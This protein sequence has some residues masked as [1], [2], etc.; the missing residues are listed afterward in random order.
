MS[1]AAESPSRTATVRPVPGIGGMG[2]MQPAVLN[3]LEDAAEEKARLGNTQRAVLNILEDVAVEQERLRDV[4]RGVFNILEDAAGERAQLRDVQRGLY[5]ILE[6]VDAERSERGRAEETVRALNARLEE[7]IDALAAANQELESFSYSV[8]HDLRAPLRAIDGFSQILIEDY[9][10]QLD[11]EGKDALNRVRAAAQRMSNLIDDMLRLSRAT[12][13]QMAI[14]P[15]DLS[16]IAA[17]VIEQLTPPERRPALEFSVQPGVI[18][19]GDAVLLRAVMENLLSNALKFTSR[20]TRGRIAFAAQRRG[21]EVICGVADDGAGFDMQ[22]AKNL[23]IPFQRLH[24]AADFP[25]NGVGLATVKRIISRLGGRVWADGAP[26]KGATFYF[27]LRD[28]G[29]D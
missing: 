6:D 27:T 29:A 5:N 15:V 8:S 14:A 11:A 17:D 4:Q 21:E 19:R 23:F 13:V 18:V 26:G 16:H 12:R 3:I 9:G 7:R 1:H 22:F 25:G 24:R 20:K 28:A 10:E 2:G